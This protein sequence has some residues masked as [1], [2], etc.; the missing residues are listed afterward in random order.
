MLLIT[1]AT[2]HL[3]SA[4]IAHLLNNTDAGNIAAYVRNE[5]KAGA[6]KQKRH[7]H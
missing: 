4:T 2:G 7:N 6:L 5:E 3:G 1:G